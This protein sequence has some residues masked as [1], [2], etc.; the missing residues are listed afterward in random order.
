MEKTDPLRMEREAAAPS[1]RPNPQEKKSKPSGAKMAA[2][3]ASER[4]N[5]VLDV[6]MG[7]V[8][9]KS[10]GAGARLGLQAGGPYKEQRGHKW[11][12]QV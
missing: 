4:L 2:G 6:L 12:P 1:A 10:S 9:R 5:D 3:Q 8:V 7:S 11:P